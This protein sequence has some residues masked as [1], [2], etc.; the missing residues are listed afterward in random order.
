MY[1]LRARVRAVPAGSA[2][3]Q[4]GM[5]AQALPAAASQI[6]PTQALELL[7]DDIDIVVPESE[8]LYESNDESV[9]ATQ[10]PTPGYMPDMPFASVRD[11]PPNL[12]APLTL[13]GGHLISTA[14]ILDPLFGPRPLG[15][16]LPAL[17]KLTITQ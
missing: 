3:P 5:G 12:G 1:N 16:L 11:T 7:D 8:V 10:P 15:I 17:H 6:T 2:R 13:Q 4:M 14:A 9:E